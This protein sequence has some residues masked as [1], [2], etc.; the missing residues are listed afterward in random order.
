[1]IPIVLTGSQT[2]ELQS[3]V[4]TANTITYEFS[5]ADTDGTTFSENSVVGGNTNSAFFAAVPAPSAGF[6]RIVKSY[7]IY[8][9]SGGNVNITFRVGGV[10]QFV[11]TRATGERIQDGIA[12]LNTG[13]QNTSGTAGTNATNFVTLTS[14]HAIVT[15]PTSINVTYGTTSN[16]GWVTGSRVR[17]SSL[18]NVNNW[19]EGTITGTPTTTA[20][21]V[22]VD[23]WSGS[24]SFSDYRMK[25]VPEGRVVVA[26][27]RTGVAMVSNGTLTINS[28]LNGTFTDYEVYLN[29][30][31]GGTTENNLID[32]TNSN[33]GRHYFFRVSRDGTA[34]IKTI[35]FAGAGRTYRKTWLTGVQ[36]IGVNE[37]WIFV[38][39]AESPTIFDVFAFRTA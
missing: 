3:S 14:T 25:V 31:T 39:H 4:A 20:A 7:N 6:R 2:I 28:Q 17:L 18:A 23:T 27:I 24:G 11:Q 29:S 38:V 32:I 1:M 12:Y 34:G 15:T 9:N 10:T 33:T 8:N 35:N 22:A 19:M 37:T 21:T 26:D 36:E 16:R 13:A 30:F 5:Y